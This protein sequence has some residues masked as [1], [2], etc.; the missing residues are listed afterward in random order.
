MNL[1]SFILGEA[2]SA[3]EEALAGQRATIVKFL[4]VNTWNDLFSNTIIPY[5][6]KIV[7]AIIIWLIGGWIIKRIMKLVAR[8]FE[9]GKVEKTIVTFVMSLTRILLY[10]LLV[11]LIM[12]MVGI[13]TASITALLGSIGLTV[14][15]ALQGS[16]SNFA[17]GVLI[18]LL[19]PFKVGNYII[20]TGVEGTVKAIDIFYTKLV[21]PDNRDIVVPN[22]ALSNANIIN[23]SGEKTRRQD[24]IASAAYGDDIDT[25]KRILADIANNNERV[26]KDQQIRV[27]IN[28]Y[29]GSSV[30]YTLRFWTKAEDYWDAR[31][32]ITEAVKKEFDAN[33]IEIPFTQMDVTIK[34]AQAEEKSR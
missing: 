24:I 3:T 17:G 9:K 4:D 22:G 21:T 30:N 2:A 14:G 34:N 33:G 18:L 13:A 19:K 28:E 26:L 15:L 6:I 7:V 12:E 11:F 31:F 16:L 27:F 10:A 23:V 32:E 20:A 29:A 25:V 5:A 8:G 1:N